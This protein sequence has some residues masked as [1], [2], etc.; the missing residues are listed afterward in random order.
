LKLFKLIREHRIFLWTLDAGLWT[1][2]IAPKKGSVSR[3]LFS[4]TVCA[5]FLF[6]ALTVLFPDTTPDANAIERPTEKALLETAPELILP[7]GPSRGFDGPLAQRAL[8]RADRKDVRIQ[9]DHF[10]TD[11]REDIRHAVSLSTRYL[12]HIV[13]ILEKYDLP[14]E[15]AYLCIIESGYRQSARSHA[16]AVGMWQMIRATS[17]RFGLTS[18]RWVDDRMDFIKSTEGAARFI[19]YLLDR[20]DDW[21]H[22]LAAYNAGEGRVRKAIQ[23]AR[24]A[25]LTPDMENLRLPRETRIY[26]PAFYAALLIAME[27]E[28]YGLFPDFQPAV[29]YIEIKMPG[30]VPLAEVALHMGSSVGSIR[31]LNPAILRDR[32]PAGKDGYM[33]RVP[34]EV[35]EGRA[36]VVAAS[37]N[38]VKYVSY[39]VR[40]GDNL[41][42][43]SRKF[44]VALSR[45]TRAGHHGKNPSRIYPGE[46]LLVALTAGSAL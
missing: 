41:W 21:D 32:I 5:V 34:C 27:P 1:R 19:R 13:P 45:I 6:A 7:P 15:L 20:F 23:R 39:R 8:F 36:R 33:L 30:G 17:T 18:D 31:S 3:A 43:I 22:V 10:L 40:K 42:N 29:D 35:G 4:G 44:G 9:L 37:L 16:G 28:R 25:G 14:P 2:N 11:K 12:N 38:E 46:V 26:V 24:K